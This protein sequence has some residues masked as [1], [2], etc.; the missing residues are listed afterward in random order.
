MGEVLCVVINFFLG[1]VDANAYA[2][3][4]FVEDVCTVSRAVHKAFF[5]AVDWVSVAADFCEVF[6]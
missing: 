2:V 1:F 4:G 6:S 5:C 3:E